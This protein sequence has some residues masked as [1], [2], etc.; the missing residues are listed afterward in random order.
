MAETPF[1][2]I[3]NSLSDDIPSD[4]LNYLPE[5]WEKIGNVLI[6]K[7]SKK[8]ANFKNIISQE[9]AKNLNCKTILND[10]GGISGEYRKPNF[11]LLFG[12]KNSET[13][14]VE[15][16]VKFRLDPQQI[17]FSSG[18]MDERIRMSLISNTNEIV[19]DL[20]AGIGYFSLPI[21]RYSKPERVYSCEI[22]PVAYNYLCNNIVLNNV[23][24]IVQPIL[25]DNK[26]VAPKNVA[27]RIIMG[28]IDKTY[29]YLPTAINC[30]K[31]NSGIIH[32]HD[33][34]PKELVPKKPFKTIT[35]ITEPFNIKAN[36]LKYHSIKSYAPR[37]NHY[38]FD[39]E[40]VKN[41]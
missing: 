32:Y 19:V 3:K 40:L 39:I 10:V 37:I 2:K 8:L 25:G 31:N 29:K 27:D 15:N 33:V 12:S 41:E 36:L 22:N 16:G 38:V 5:K 24:S 14:H 20:F 21:A 9:Y 4:L 28:C 35:E 1:D 18:N 17:M 23:T 26:K 34:Y 11:E 7:L 30:L 13:V 6:I